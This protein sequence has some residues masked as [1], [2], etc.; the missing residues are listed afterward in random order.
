VG[1]NETPIGSRILR[2]DWSRD[3][4]HVTWHWRLLSRSH[5]VYEP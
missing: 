2:V 1:V 5:S 4:R 3:S